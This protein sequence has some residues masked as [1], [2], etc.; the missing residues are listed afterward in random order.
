M[1]WGIRGKYWLCFAV[2]L[3]LTTGVVFAHLSPVFALRH[4]QVRGPYADKLKGLMQRR[5][6]MRE[7]LFAMN[8]DRLLSEALLPNEIGNVKLR[9]AIP[10]GL[11]T[12][13]NRFQPVALL[14][15]DQ[16][17]GIDR[18]CR[19]VPFDTAWKEM[20]LPILTGLAAGHLFEAPSD[21]RVAGIIAGL[22]SARQ[23]LPDLY[24]QIAEIDFSDSLYIKIYMTTS[25]KKFLATSGDFVSQLVK[26]QAINNLQNW[27][28]SVYYNLLYDGVIVR[29]NN[30]DKH[31][32]GADSSRT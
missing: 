10:G 7:N 29:E 30:E 1:F 26:M 31:V 18:F 17:L 23:S 22:D 20:D 25:A 4:T 28:D 27:S 12:E 19:V 2:T 3:L 6:Q 21:F 11:L 14:W 8:K 5:Q 15:K 9:L 24:D 32:A 16:L 13:V